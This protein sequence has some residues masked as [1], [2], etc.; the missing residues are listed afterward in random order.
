MVLKCSLTSL[1]L[2][3]FWRHFSHGNFCLVL[4]YFHFSLYSTVTNV[5]FFFAV[6]WSFSSWIVFCSTLTAVPI[7]LG[8]VRSASVGCGGGPGSGTWGA[9]GTYAAFSSISASAAGMSAPSVR[10]ASMAVCVSS[11]VAA[12]V[13]MPEVPGCVPSVVVVGFHAGMDADDY[14]GLLQTGLGPSRGLV[15]YFSAAIRVL[16]GLLLRSTFLCFLDGEGGLVL[17]SNCV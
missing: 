9:N 10:S 5:F 7:T 15:L 14:D 11:S 1:W 16:D 12:M 4:T 8:S 3:K 6:G 2:P 17:V 13:T